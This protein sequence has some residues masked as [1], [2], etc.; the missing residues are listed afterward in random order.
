MRTGAPERSGKTDAEVEGQVL[1][2]WAGSGIR[3]PPPPDLQARAL[4]PEI[5]HQAGLT[6][7]VQNP[8][9]D[10]LLPLTPWHLGQIDPH[11]PVLS[12]DNCFPAS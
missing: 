11:P 12:P 1:V 10:P 5:S 6:L 7:I 4:Q 8:D 2:T 3:P 9:L